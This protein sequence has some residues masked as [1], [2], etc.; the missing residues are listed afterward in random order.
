MEMVVI[1]VGIIVQSHASVASKEFVINIK[2]MI[3]K[4]KHNLNACLFKV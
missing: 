4:I 3:W 1:S 2:I